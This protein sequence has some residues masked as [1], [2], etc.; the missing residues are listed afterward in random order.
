MQKMIDEYLDFVKSRSRSSKTHSTYQ[1][2]LKVFLGAVGDDAQLTKATYIDFLKKTSDM[3][4]ASQ[5]LCR[6]VIKSLYSF[7]ADKDPAIVTAFFPQV[8]KEYAVR[9]P[10]NELTYN[11]PGIEKIIGYCNAIRSGL[12]DLRDRAF[13]LFLADTGLRVA[14]ACSLQIAS[15]DWN[16]AKAHF[17]GKGRKKASA[18]VSKRAISALQD[19]LQERGN[20]AKSQPLFIRHDKKAGSEIKPVEP[21]GMWYAIKRR[22]VE[23]GVDPSTIRV[24][25]F[26]HYFV[27]V[28]YSSSRDIRLA[29][30]LAR[31]KKI[32]TTARYAH[33][34]DDSGE[35]YNEIF[36]KV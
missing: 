15:V 12:A 20:P 3:N 6:S 28:V 24:H 19:Y 32:D 29:Q 2:A 14:E 18:H 26:R 13:I 21:G 35:A 16:E 4:P 1:Q 5:A 23:A 33:L 30:Q 7:Q 27:T 25:D 22:A 11:Q 36:N 9:N 17:I 8:N 34:I 31:H 10:D